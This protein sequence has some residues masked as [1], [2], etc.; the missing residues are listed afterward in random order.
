M[1]F[2]IAQILLFGGKKIEVL[3]QQKLEDKLHEEEI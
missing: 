2:I 3:D 1:L